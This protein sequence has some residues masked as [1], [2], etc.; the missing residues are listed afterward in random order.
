MLKINLTKEKRKELQTYLKEEVG[1]MLSDR[2][3]LEGRWAK[4]ERQY[5]GKSEEEKKTFPWNGACNVVVPVT[6]SIIDALLARIADIWKVKPF[7]TVRSLNPLIDALT[8]PISQ[9]LEWANKHELKLFQTMIPTLLSVLKFGNGFG[10]L[11][12]VGRNPFTASPG[13][14]YRH[15]TIQD[16]VF[17]LNC[18]DIHTAQWVGDRCRYTLS[19]LK[20]LENQGLLYNIT[21][22]VEVD[23]ED[24]EQ[25]E[26]TLEQQV[27]SSTETESGPT[28]YTLFDLWM[29]WDIN[30]D[31]VDEEIH[32]ICSW[33]NF[34]IHGLWMNEYGHR[35]YR[36]FKMFPREN[37]V[38]A[39]GLCE[40]LSDLQEEITAMHR[41][42]TDNATLANTR[43]FKGRA[44]ATGVKPGMKI[45]PGRVIT[46]D[47]PTG[48]LV[49][50][51]LGEI[52]PSS[53]QAEMVLMSMIEKRAGLSD[54]ALGKAP[55][56]ETATTT[57]ALIQEGNK[58][59]EFLISYIKAELAEL[60]ADYI[61]LHRQFAPSDKVIRIV[62]PE[63]QVSSLILKMPDES[64]R[65]RI[66]LEVTAGSELAAKEVE[67]QQLIQLFG[68]FK[69]FYMSM[70]ELAMMISNPNVPPMVQQFAIK[71]SVAATKFM[72]QI[73]DNFNLRD[74]KEMIP[75]LLDTFGGAQNGG[76]GG[77]M[78]G[79]GAQPGMESMQGG[80][81]GAVEGNGG[82]GMDLGNMG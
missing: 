61:E 6:G 58:R 1:Q 64:L 54:V 65:G 15:I 50:E 56:R 31:K 78:G 9:L 30:N 69:E 3:E 18:L 63:G 36:H 11:T 43:F 5:E 74:I 2:K 25:D 60:G 57:L 14:L 82:P 71:V 72:E 19:D 22:L 76:N 46:L 52:Y 44:G 51:Q 13:G 67:R 32:V 62:G 47:D 70:F 33:P 24:M 4:W 23:P 35:P 37:N 66:L 10:K 73:G 41:Q 38:Y 39:M 81:A 79:P 80:M 40:Y 20:K 75:S 26:L 16:M 27:L 12:W 53:I 59:L 49:T 34:T 7:F 21:K 17:P 42:R 8:K 55:R 48:D 77:G 29:G 45:W 28:P 68:L